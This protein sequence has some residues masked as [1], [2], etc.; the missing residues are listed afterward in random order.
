MTSTSGVRDAKRLPAA[1]EN[2]WDRVVSRELSGADGPG[3]VYAYRNHG[4]WKAGR[5]RNI[6]R[7]LREWAQDCPSSNRE[8]VGW[9]ATPYV[10]QTEYL[11]HLALETVCLSR[12]R[13][14]CN[15]GKTHLELFELGDDS[16]M[17]E[18]LILEV[19]EMVVVFVLAKY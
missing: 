11:L 18:D 1:L 15:C 4:L 12:P 13:F 5:T 17:A 8:W 19:M 9:R 14:Q 6:Q 7:R 2:L 16:E 10:N 3:V